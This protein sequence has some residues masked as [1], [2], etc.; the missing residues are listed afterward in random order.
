MIQFTYLGQRFFSYE[1]KTL[2]SS[3]F[4]SKYSSHQPDEIFVALSSPLRT[5]AVF[6]ACTMF[7]TLLCL[8]NCSITSFVTYGVEP[9][10]AARTGADFLGTIEDCGG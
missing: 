1:S 5:S 8:M 2:P 6:C 4:Y 10:G 9:G 7:S 3:L